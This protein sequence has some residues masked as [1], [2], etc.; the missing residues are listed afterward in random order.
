MQNYRPPFGYEEHIFFSEFWCPECVEKSLKTVAVQ[1]FKG[2]ENELVVLRFLLKYGKVL[3]RL[4]IRFSTER[5][6]DDVDMEPT[7][8]QNLQS[9]MTSSQIASSHL[10]VYEYDDE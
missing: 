2:E 6:A 8:R 3:E 9:L 1:G 4:N 10:Q 7:Y 5:G